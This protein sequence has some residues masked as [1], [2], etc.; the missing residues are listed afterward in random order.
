ML[1]CLPR[2][3]DKYQIR[4]PEPDGREHPLRAETGENECLLRGILKSEDRFK[5]DAQ[6]SEAK[7]SEPDPCAADTDGRLTYSALEFGVARAERSCKSAVDRSVQS[8]RDDVHAEVDRK[9]L[10]RN[11]RSKSATTPRRWGVVRGRGS[12]AP[13]QERTRKGEGT[14]DSQR[15]NSPLPDAAFRRPTD[16]GTP[17]WG[18][19]ATP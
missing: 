2:S 6:L 9:N 7:P 16:G 4:V 12:E 15:R 13:P 8:I 18:R 11:R 10:A 14:T 3:T 1:F 17:H 5:L 19:R